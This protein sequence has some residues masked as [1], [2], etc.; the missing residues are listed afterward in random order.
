M[1]NF[2]ISYFFEKI[3]SQYLNVISQKN[4]LN[5]FIIF[6]IFTFF[7]I[8]SFIPVIK[9]QLEPIRAVFQNL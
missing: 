5:L 3:V 8:E 4:I 2:S 1:W 9:N 7:P 6:N